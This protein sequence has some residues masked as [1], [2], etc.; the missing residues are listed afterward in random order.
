M[1]RKTEK[2]IVRTAGA[3]VTRGYRNLYH[4]ALQWT[5]RTAK[6]D[7]MKMMQATIKEA[8]KKGFVA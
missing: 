4:R 3:L 1:T 2:D 7:T 6:E 8:K 5:G